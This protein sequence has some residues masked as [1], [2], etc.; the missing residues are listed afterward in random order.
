MLKVFEVIDRNLVAEVIEPSAGTGVFSSLV[1]D[2]PCVAYDI[3]PEGDYIIEAD[4]LKLSIPYKKG[5]LVL[6]NPPFGS[7][8]NMSLQF[9]KKSTEISDY[10]AFIQPISQY[11]NTYQMYHFDLI[12]SIDLGV[13]TFSDSRK[14]HC[15]F[16][17]WSRPESG[18]INKPYKKQLDQIKFKE[19]RKSRNQLLPSDWQYD[20]GI[21]TW[22]SV[23][24]IVLHQGQFNQEL[25]I[26]INTED[27]EEIIKELIEVDWVKEYPMTKS[28]RLKQWQVI[29]FIKKKFPN[30]K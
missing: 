5:R 24:E 17:I 2:M 11:K 14:V 6:G 3:K 25:Y 20:I 23:G 26:K 7:K 4:F 18:I 22:G 13:V 30:I 21:C 12:E 27:K 8:N 29:D 9:F 28:P 16:N 10:I 1:N 19:V 15:C